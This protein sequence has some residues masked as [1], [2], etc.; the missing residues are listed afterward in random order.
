MTTEDR[1]YNG[2]T[3]YE[4]WNVKL[5]IDNDEGSCRYWQDTADEILDRNTE[6]TTDDDG[7]EAKEFDTD[8][9][10]SELAD[11]LSTEIKDSAPDLGASCFAD[12]LNAALS[13]VDWYE[14]AQSMIDDAKERASE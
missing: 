4:T 12:L 2:W 10:K 8:T 5:W 14:I 11:Q 9:A 1:K 7:N 13:K 6:T 3:N